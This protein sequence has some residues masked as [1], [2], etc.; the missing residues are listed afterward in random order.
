M[1]ASPLKLLQIVHTTGYGGLER[2]VLSLSLGLRDAGHQ[3]CFALQPDSWLSKQADQHGFGWEPV[4]YRGLFDPISHLRIRRLIRQN[5]IDVVHGHSRRSATYSATAGRIAHCGSVAT[6]HSLETWKGF[7]RNQKMIAVSEAVRSFLQSKGVPG[8]QIERIYNG[9]D[10]NQRTIDTE[11]VLIRS[12]LGLGEDQI[13]VAMVGRMVE[14]KGHD[15]LIRALSKLGPKGMNFRLFLIGH[16]SGPW[17]RELWQLAELLGVQDRIVM[18]GYHDDVTSI[19]RGM[20][21]FVQP[22]RS[23]ALS[24]SLLEAMSVG[25]PVIAARTGGM[26]EVVQHGDNGLLFAAGSASDLSAQLECLRDQEDRKRL[27]EAGRNTQATLFSTRPMVDAT[28]ALYRSVL[29]RK[30]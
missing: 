8:E 21:I 10:A 11:R 9:V 29:E 16:P 25:L 13:A 1:K 18:P 23:E 28:V 14:H 2:Q 26:P 12:R 5:Q 17:V 7:A 4:R 20:D 22:S 15:L 19:L 24:L 27:A 30:A 6:V 3:V